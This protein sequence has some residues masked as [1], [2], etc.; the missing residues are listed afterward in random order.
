[1]IKL[2][3]TTYEMTPDKKWNPVVTHVLYGGTRKEVYGVLDAHMKIDQFFAGSYKG[4]WRGLILT[5]SNVN[6]EKLFDAMK[7]VI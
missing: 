2:T 3:I 6:V 4:Q 5:N 7:A 1:M